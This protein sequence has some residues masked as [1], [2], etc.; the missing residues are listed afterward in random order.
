MPLANIDYYSV[1]ITSNPD[2]NNDGTPDS[3]GEM[4]QAFRN[5]FIDLASGELENFQFS[6]NVQETQLIQGI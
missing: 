4:Y 5:N 6:C 1:E 2:F 3:E